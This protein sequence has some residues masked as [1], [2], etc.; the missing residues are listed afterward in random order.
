M[1]CWVLLLLSAFIALEL[2]NANFYSFSHLHGGHLSSVFWISLIIYM[3]I[4][5][6]SF[7]VFFTRE[8][9]AHEKQRREMIEYK[10]TSE[11][12]F[13]RSQ[14]NPHFLFNTLNNL[15]SLAQ[16]H[17]NNELASGIYK[18]S[19]LMRYVLYDSS[20]DKVSLANEMIYIKDF[21]GLNKLRY[22]E[23]EVKVDISV[24][25]D[26]GACSIAPMILIPFIENAFKH[27]VRA[28]AHSTI[29]IKIECGA[30]KVHFHC[31]NPIFN[32][33][34][35]TGEGGIGLENVRRRLALLYPGRHR[36]DIENDGSTYSVDLELDQ[37]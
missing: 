3:V 29:L 36:L 22:D 34:S 25:G 37:P 31:R 20:A 18:L 15:F 28:E 1:V 6:I 21:I 9:M 2:L 33:P 27:G 35:V 11:L 5:S 7:A 32:N 23:S 4:I 24:A 26:P 19:G 8:W 14:I 17:E 12:N 10:L 13:L 30:G 16:K